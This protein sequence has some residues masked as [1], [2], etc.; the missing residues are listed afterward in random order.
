MRRG[1]QVWCSAEAVS[2]E[3]ISICVAFNTCIPWRE[4]QQKERL[5]GLNTGSLTFRDEEE[6]LAEMRRVVNG[7]GRPGSRVFADTDC[8]R[9]SREGS[10]SKA[11][12]LG[13]Y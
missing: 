12:G 13:V 2:L 3:V 7:G 1:S 6:D 4:C 11:S 9:S 5:P 8:E 10:S